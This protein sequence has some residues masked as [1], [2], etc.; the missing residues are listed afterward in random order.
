MRCVSEADC[1]LMRCRWHWPPTT[2]RVPGMSEETIVSIDVIA[3]PRCGDLG[4]CLVLYDA[5]IL[6]QYLVHCSTCST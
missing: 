2:L 1:A 4:S 3:G 5:S 6:V